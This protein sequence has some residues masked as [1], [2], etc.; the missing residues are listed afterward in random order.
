STY[1]KRWSRNLTAQITDRLSWTKCGIL[2]ATIRDSTKLLRRSLR[3]CSP[4]PDQPN[5][6]VRKAA[7]TAG[8]RGANVLNP[9]VLP[10]L[11]RLVLTNICPQGLISGYHLDYS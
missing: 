6:A 8:L 2:C 5:G 3:S 10:C 7:A 9:S 11:A 1:Y 4:G